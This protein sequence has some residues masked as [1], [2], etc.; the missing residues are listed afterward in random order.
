MAHAEKSITRDNM[1]ERIQKTCENIPK[2][3]LVENVQNFQN[4]IQ[5]CLNQNDNVFKYLS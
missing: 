2:D 5:L 4:K 3:V 1:K